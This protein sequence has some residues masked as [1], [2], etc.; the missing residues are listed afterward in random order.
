MP[1]LG[2]P[3][4]RKFYS[5]PPPCY[6]ER[7]SSSNRGLMRIWTLSLHDLLKGS[8][9]INSNSKAKEVSLMNPSSQQLVCLSIDPR[10]ATIIVEMQ[11][12]VSQ[13]CVDRTKSKEF[14]DVGEA[15]AYRI[16]EIR[17][18]P[19]HFLIFHLFFLIAYFSFYGFF[20]TFSLITL[21]PVRCLMGTR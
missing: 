20:Q 6:P 2:V 8:F 5:N 1:Y 13:N 19:T 11:K 21:V 10:H 16:S 9:S 12:H 15:N 18:Q 7:G 4:R 3:K 14:L 17:F